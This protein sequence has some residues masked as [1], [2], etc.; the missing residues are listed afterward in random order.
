MS[1]HPPVSLITAKYF[2]ALQQLSQI[3]SVVTLGEVIL[4]HKEVK[5]Y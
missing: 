1:L 2:Y 4:Q 3:I 5:T